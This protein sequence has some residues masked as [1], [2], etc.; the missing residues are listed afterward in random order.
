MFRENSDRL[1]ICFHGNDHTAAELASTD[2]AL[3]NTMLGIAEERMNGHEQTTGLRC[4][5]V[6]VF[7]QGR[8]S[9]EAMEILKCRN[10]HAAVNTV[11]AP[12]GLQLPLTIADFAQPAVLRYG[13]F[14]LFI[15]T[16]VKKTQSEDIAFNVFF[17]RPVLIVEHHDIFRH[18]ES[19]VDVVQKVNSVVP[20]IFWSNLESAV[21]SSILRRRAPDETLQVRAYS[22]NVRVANDSAAVERFS[23]E[24]GRLGEYSPF[25]QVLQDGVRL[26]GVDVDDAG[27]RVSAELA[28]HT[29]QTFSV[30]YRS[31]Q[32]TNRDL[33]FRWNAKAFLRKSETITLVGINTY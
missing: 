25:E 32:A 31:A 28:P 7:P 14:P 30:L 24:W 21:D 10:F 26:S 1:S 12:V 16:Y 9:I 3:L 18:P 29:S 4:G 23:I 5:K 20:G 13:G 33:G 17:G 22:T 11:H 6:M 15:R 19:L 27:I 8:F 2:T